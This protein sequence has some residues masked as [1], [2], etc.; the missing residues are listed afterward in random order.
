MIVAVIGEKGG[1]GKTTFAAHLAGG[2]SIAGSDVMLVDADK[3]ESSTRWVNLRQDRGLFAPE[4]VQKF[5]RGLRRAVTDLSRRYDDIIVDIGAGDGVAM[6]TTLRVADT[7]VVPLQPNEMDMWTVDFLDGLAADSKELNEKLV[8]RAVLNRAPS[9]HTERDVQA[10]LKAFADFPEMQPAEF[11]VH[12]RSSI[13]RAVPAGLLID[14]W[15][16]RDIK[17]QAELAQMYRLVFGVDAPI[18]D[19]LITDASN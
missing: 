5:A 8:V 10:A 12:E 17:A 4:S 15:R 9:H 1:T 2:R 13:R 14:E 3:Q 11:T 6:E 16:P 18:A 19:A 7:A